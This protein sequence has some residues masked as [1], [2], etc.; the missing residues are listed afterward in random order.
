MYKKYVKRLLDIVFSLILLPPA[1]LVILICGILIKLEDGG[2]IFYCG[3]RLGKNGKIFKMYKLRSMKVN[4]PDLRNSDGS[5]YNSEDDPRLTKVG[6]ILRKTSIDELPQIF[7][8]LKGDMSFVGPRP[9][10]PE[11]IMYYQGKEI[12]KIEVMPGIT[13][14]NQAYFRNS[15]T[16]K[17]RLQNDLYY[18]ENISFLLDLKIIIK[19]VEQVLFR[20]GIFITSQSNFVKGDG[21]Y[22]QQSNRIQ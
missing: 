6:R 4:A 9:D 14:Y 20:K 5:T 2:P 10:L 22:E 8:V 15:I 13:G 18:V 7:N 3:I 11:H 12:K 1:I 21:I 19:T 17:K 16:W